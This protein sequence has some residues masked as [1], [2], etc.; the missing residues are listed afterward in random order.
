VKTVEAP[1]IAILFC[2]SGSAAIFWRTS[3]SLMIIAS[4]VPGGAMIPFQ[5][6]AL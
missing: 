1:A 2:T 3:E 6:S 4:G 5:D